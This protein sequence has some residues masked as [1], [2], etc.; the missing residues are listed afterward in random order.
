MLGKRKLRDQKEQKQVKKWQEE[1]DEDEDDSDA[2]LSDD[3]NLQKLIKESKLIDQNQFEVDEDDELYMYHQ[4]LFK[5]IFFKAE[6][7][8]RTIFVWNITEQAHESDLDKI[9]GQHDL[10]RAEGMTFNKGRCFIEFTNP[11]SAQKAVEEVNEK[12]ELKGKMLQCLIGISG[13]TSSKF[14]DK[15]ILIEK[16][17]KKEQKLLEIQEK[18]KQQRKEQREIEKLRDQEQSDDEEESSDEYESEDEELNEINVQDD[19]NQRLQNGNKNQ[20]QEETFQI[21]TM[22]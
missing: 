10:L 7:D 4:N 21:N 1:L 22:L 9:F 11:E 8:K 2:D 13:A 15:Q 17:E 12:V 18:R 6:K 14:Q 20:D 16:K 3:E 19:H 5:C